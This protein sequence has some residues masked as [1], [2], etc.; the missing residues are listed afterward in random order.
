MSLSHYMAVC[1]VHLCHSKHAT[2]VPETGMHVYI[3]MLLTPI[4]WYAQLYCMCIITEW[5][6]GTVMHTYIVLHVYAHNNDLICPPP[7]HDQ[8]GTRSTD[9]SIHS[10]STPVVW[11][12]FAQVLGGGEP[13]NYNWLPPNKTE[14]NW[15]G[16]HSNNTRQ[17]T[18]N[19]VTFNCLGMHARHGDPVCYTLWHHKTK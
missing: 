4:Q 7:A 17:W 14:H 6:T 16:T 18:F 3:H 15:V 8:C 2:A 19:I 1:I 13:A 5:H 9:Y 12:A 10:C 11:G